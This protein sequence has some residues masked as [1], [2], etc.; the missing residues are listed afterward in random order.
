MLGDM[1]RGMPRG[2]IVVTGIWLLL[3]WLGAGLAATPLSL[4]I[5]VA[6]IDHPAFQAGA[7]RL[8]LEDNGEDAALTLHIGRLQLAGLEGPLREVRLACPRLAR[9]W[10][11]LRC[12]EATLTVGDSPW[13]PQRLSLSVDWRGDGRGVLRFSGLRLAGDRLRGRLTLDGARW[14]LR[15]RARRLDPARLPP[16]VA[17][18]AERGL[19]G[20]GGRLRGE[21]RVQGEGAR[22][23]RVRFEGGFSELA[24]SD[25]AGEQAAEG[26]AGTL[27]LDLRHEGSG[28]RGR[29]ALALKAGEIYSDPLFLDLKQRPLALTARGRWADE[30]LWLEHFRLDDGRALRLAGQAS[31]TLSPFALREAELAFDSG[32]LG[33]LHG[34]WGQP[35]LLDTPLEELRAAGSAKGHLRWRHGKAAALD[36]ELSGVRIAGEVPLGIEGLSGEVHWRAEGAAPDSRLRLDGLHLGRLA[37]GATTLAFNAS[38]PAAYLRQPLVIPFHEGILRIPEATWVLTG[39]GAEGGFS[40][41]LH[42]V[43]LASLSRALDWPRMEGRVNAE[44]PRARYRGGTLKVD[45]DIVIEAFDGR[46]VIGDLALAEIGSAAP[47]LTG[48]LRLRRLDLLALTRTFSFGDM[49]GRLDGEIEGLR[50]VAWQPD[51]FQAR[52]FTSP[53]DDRP[54]RISQ[55]AVENLTELGNG[56]S[57]ALSTGFLSL[58]K[59]FGYDRIELRIR[60]RGDRAWIDGIPAGG[61][62]YYLVKGAGIPRIDV[63]G[64]NRE[65]AWKDLVARLRSIRVEG[66]QMR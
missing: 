25:P 56:V 61:G 50:L 37:F 5:G 21:L 34:R 49:Q 40:L 41:R 65:V 38:G 23:G 29:V 54:H 62:G 44:I 20:V 26:V 7:L 10:P 2:H 13:G 47:V 33:A 6:D 36:L 46:I 51:R 59:T 28:W 53:D 32:D 58:F 15:V 52:F 17:A 30:Q 19:D 45:G 12:Q 24:W 43:S 55:R 4:E 3:A 11:R 8:R 18:L 16:L 1:E 14:S 35:W 60:Q 66:M 63:I 48:R 22:P 31:L 64:R 9:P 39:Q 57:G 42:E 27:D